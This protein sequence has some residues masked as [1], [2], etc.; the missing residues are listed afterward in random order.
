[1][2][3]SF[4][5]TTLAYVFYPPFVENKYYVLTVILASFWGMTFFNFSGIRIS[6][7]F[8]TFCVIAGTILPGI[9][10]IGLGISWVLA[11]EP[12]QIQLTAESLLPDLSRLDNI[13]FLG[14][15]FLSFAG[16][17]VTS[18]YAGEVQNPQRN[19]P[20]GYRWRPGERS[21]GKSGYV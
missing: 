17:E 21:S 2:I 11:G 13:V 1:V 4:V 16:L 20:G 14:G 7:W 5:A 19:Y 3:L 6:S 12:L 18:G 8:S 9:F 10:L 15:L